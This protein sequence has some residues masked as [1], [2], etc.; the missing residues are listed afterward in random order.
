LNSTAIALDNFKAFLSNPCPMAI[1]EINDTLLN[2]LGYFKEDVIGKT[3][4][5]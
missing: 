1:S 5:D 3:S 4:S 2:T